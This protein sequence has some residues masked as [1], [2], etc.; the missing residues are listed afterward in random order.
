MLTEHEKHEINE[1]IAHYDFKLAAAVD[2][3]KIVQANRGGWVSDESLAD[4]AGYLGMSVAEL[5]S[6][7]TFYN[8]IRRRPVGRHVILI[9]NSISCWIMGYTNICEHIGKGLGIGL[10]QTTP[11]GRFTLLPNACLGCCDKAPAMMV[12]AQLYTDLTPEKVD[13][14]LAGYE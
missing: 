8:I 9:C 7:A 1:E 6:V 4:V 10:G 5:D 14:I 12:D 2:A 11:D 3:L 13:T